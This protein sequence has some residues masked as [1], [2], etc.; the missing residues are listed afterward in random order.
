RPYFDLNHEDGPASFWPERYEWSDTPAPGIYVSG[1]LTGSG[2]AAIEGKD[3][4]QFSPVFHVDNKRAKPAR[5]VCREDA[6]PN[7]GGF[8]NDPAF[9]QILPLWAKNADGA[10]PSQQKE[11]LVNMTPEQLAALQAK[12]TELQKEIDALKSEQSALKAKQQ[13]DELVASKIEAKEALLKAS[14]TTLENESLKAKAAKLE[15]D[16]LARRQSHA[17][18]FVAD[19]VKRG[20]VAAKD[21]A[22]LAEIEK[23]VTDNPATFEPIYAKWGGAQALETRIVASNGAERIVVTGSDPRNVFSA[24]E[25]LV[26]KNS[27]CTDRTEKSKLAREMAA[28]YAAEFRHDSRIMDSPLISANSVG[29]LAG[30]LVVQRVLELLKLTFPALTRFSTDF[31]DQPASY[32]QTVTTRIVSIPTV[33]T[34]NTSTGWTASDDTTTDV[35]VTINAHKGVPITFDSNTL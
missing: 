23:N 31:S 19:M 6:K 24:Y 1:E 22:A 25:A 13:N 30:T 14:Q 28:I 4:R 26:A 3:Y 27:A 10:H 32:N 20:A 35:S 7:M 29:T 9:N 8:V 15:A 18:Q 34:Y 5:I 12:N 2:R 16:D 33:Q 17:K 21:T 11:N